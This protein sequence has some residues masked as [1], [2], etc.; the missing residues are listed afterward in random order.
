MIRLDVEQGT[1]AWMEARLGIPTASNFARIVTPTGRLSGQRDQYIAELLAEWATGNPVSDFSD[2]WTERGKVLELD[3]F[4]EYG[5]QTDLDPE[6]VGFVYS[7][8]SHMVGGSPDGLVGDDGLIELKCPKVENH[9]LYLAR[10]VVPPKYVPQCQ[11]LLW[12]TGRAWCD[13][14]S[15]YPELPPLIVRVEPDD[16]YQEA[17]DTHLPTFVE[18]LLEGRARLKAMGVREALQR[19]EGL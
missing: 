5:F 16:K 4:Y 7:D 6:K 8:E 10:G 1:A 18:E 14:M 11:G 19:W 15:F 17:L 3:A 2:E 13:F 9:L 12:V